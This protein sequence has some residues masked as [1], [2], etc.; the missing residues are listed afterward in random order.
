MN[1]SISSFIVKGNFVLQVALY[2]K[3]FDV[4]KFHVREWILI[5]ESKIHMREGIVIDPL[6]DDQEWNGQSL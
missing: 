2:K 4:S 6:E 1:D 5:E 3:G